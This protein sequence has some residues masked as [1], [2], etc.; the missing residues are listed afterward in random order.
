MSFITFLDLVD[1]QQPRQ[2]TTTTVT[3]KFG[4]LSILALTVHVTAA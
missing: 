1:Y 4:S 2:A 3:M